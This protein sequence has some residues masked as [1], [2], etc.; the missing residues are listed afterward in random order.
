MKIL[1]RAR[2]T[3]RER[4]VAAVEMAIV[5]PVFVVL[6][7]FPIFVGRVLMNFTMADKAAHDAARVFSMAPPTDVRSLSRVNHWVNLAKA[8]ADAEL[9]EL[10]LEDGY[11]VYT[12]LCGTFICDGLST[13]ST[14]RFAIRYPIFDEVFG[15]TTG[16]A[17]G[18]AITA[19]ATMPYVGE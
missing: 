14:F 3:G 5:L 6:L 13:P 8:V 4:G 9:E 11:P 2:T 17:E 12:P 7:A 16:G 19:D 10:H 15:E 18:L 1:N